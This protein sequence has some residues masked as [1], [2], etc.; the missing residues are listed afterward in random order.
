M[1]V[2]IIIE[3][4]MLTVEVDHILNCFKPKILIESRYRSLEVE[5]IE[6]LSID[7]IVIVG[8]IILIN[9]VDILI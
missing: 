1:K 6:R 5:V 2:V 4:K 3:M 9:N 8:R 7:D